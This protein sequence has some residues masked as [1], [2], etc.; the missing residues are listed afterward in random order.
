LQEINHLSQIFDLITVDESEGRLNFSN[1]I[2]KGKSFEV[3][4]EYIE[5]KL[6][7]TQNDKIIENV[8]IDLTNFKKLTKIKLKFYKRN[9]LERIFF[10]RNYANLLKKIKSISE[11]YSWL[12]IPKKY[13]YIIKKFDSYSENQNGHNSILNCIGKFETLNL[14]LNPNNEVDK[15]YFGN[16]NSATIL[17]R[18]DNSKLEYYLIETG[19][20][21]ELQII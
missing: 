17:V 13:L 5:Y 7:L 6:S 18:R 10:K 14:F 3:K 12:I 9:F 16:Y 8:L 4:N 20:S 1:T 15:L 19:E 11:N 21:T 2:K